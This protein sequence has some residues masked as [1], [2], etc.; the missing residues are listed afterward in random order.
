[1]SIEDSSP[2]VVE[3]CSD[4]RDDGCD[5]C[6]STFLAGIIALHHALAGLTRI[7]FF[8]KWS[9]VVQ[10]HGKRGKKIAPMIWSWHLPGASESEPPV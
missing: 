7:G 3:V 8:S 2:R 6:E 5:C 9:A 10:E 4:L 1:M